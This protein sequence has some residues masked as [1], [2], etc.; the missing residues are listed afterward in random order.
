[1][2]RLDSRLGAL[3]GAVEGRLE[4]ELFA[5]FALLERH[6]DKP[7]FLRVMEILASEGYTNGYA[8]KGG[9]Q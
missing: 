9:P 4:E 7:T 3:E 1:M 8:L 2:R 6:L 5:L